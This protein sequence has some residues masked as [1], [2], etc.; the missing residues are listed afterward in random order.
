[1]AEPHPPSQ[2]PEQIAN[3]L[4]QLGAQLEAQGRVELALEA[5]SA[6]P[7]IQAE[8][9]RAMVNKGKRLEKPGRKNQSLLTFRAVLAE[10]G[11]ASDSRV[12]KQVQEARKLVN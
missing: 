8:V 1:M 3:A 2:P 11:N 10:F 9:A 7:Q 5:Y 12:L 4:I 6:E